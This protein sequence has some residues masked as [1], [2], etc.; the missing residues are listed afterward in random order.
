[1]NKLEGGGLKVVDARAVLACGLRVRGGGGDF[2]KRVRG[3]SDVCFSTTCPLTNATHALSLAAASAMRARPPRTGARQ[4]P[5][6]QPPPL[7]GRRAAPTSATPVPPV[8]RA[9]CGAL[10]PV[11][12]PMPRRRVDSAAVDVLAATAEALADA[13]SAA[14]GSGGLTIE[15]I[16][17]PFLW[18]NS[19]ITYAWLLLILAPRWAGV[20]NVWAAACVSDPADQNK[21]GNATRCAFLFLRGRP[22]GREECSPRPFFWAQVSVGTASHRGPR[23]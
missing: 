1:M 11:F 23:L 13:S 9:P 20:A 3:A 8:P 17:P 16:T 14:G 21:M 10:V 7:P 6:A 2:R 22:N 5:R 4:P 15:S 19:A 18:F 12:V